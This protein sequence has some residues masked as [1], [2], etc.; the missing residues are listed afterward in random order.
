MNTTRWATRLV[1]AGAFAA[2][3]VSCGPKQAAAPGAA[4]PEVKGK[5]GVTCM[6]LTNP[7]F[8]LIG[9]V[10]QEEAAKHGYEV[11]VLS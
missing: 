4:K 7:F 3:A 11:V 10:M 1:L 2:L 9:N 6:D 8:K 5:I